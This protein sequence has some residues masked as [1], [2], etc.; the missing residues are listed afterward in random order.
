MP[1]AVIEVGKCYMTA[2]GE[3]RRVLEISSGKVKY[4]TQQK[5]AGG[6]SST[7]WVTVGDG[8]FANDVER[9]VPCDYDPNSTPRWRG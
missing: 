1:V 2:F 6:G 7:S 8:R 3:I 4:E 9:E 5:T